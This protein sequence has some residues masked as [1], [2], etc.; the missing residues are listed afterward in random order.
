[1]F[2]LNSSVNRFAEHIF[3]FNFLV[4]FIDPSKHITVPHGDVPFIDDDKNHQGP[5][6]TIP[7]S[8]ESSQTVLEN[9]VHGE[10]C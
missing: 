1:M 8:T 2:Q 9:P 4:V 10:S 6:Q 5:V 3:S 7:P